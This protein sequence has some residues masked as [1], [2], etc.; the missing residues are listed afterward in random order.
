MMKVKAQAKWVRIGPR[1]LARVIDTVRGKQALDA[2]DLLKF[3]PQKGARVLEKVIKSA[4]ANARNN[5]KLEE[6]TLVLS[7][8]FANKAIIMR[9]F[10]ARARGR[11][12]PINKRTSHL[13]VFVSAPVSAAPAEEQAAKAKKAKPKRT[14]KK[15]QEEA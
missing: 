5:Y 8:A 2:L 9:R 7:E 11:A 13:T 1:K 14:R 6:A 3:M 4:V 10:Q 15:K 12:F